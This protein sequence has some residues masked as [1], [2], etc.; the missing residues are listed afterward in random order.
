MNDF[1]ETKESFMNCVCTFSIDISKD[2]DLSFCVFC[3]SMDHLSE[4]IQI[5]SSLVGPRNPEKVQFTYL[6]AQT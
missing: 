6:V 3:W 1:V 4:S 5:K 2:L